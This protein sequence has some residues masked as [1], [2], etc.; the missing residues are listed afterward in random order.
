MTDSDLIKANNIKEEIRE[1]DLFIYSA[2]KVWKGK[3][4]KRTSKYI[5]KS[6][7]FGIFDEVEYHMNTG[8]KNKV[9]DVLREHLQDL[10][11]Q[12]KIL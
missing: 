4:T 3:L 10:K 8:M 12:L 7:A 9:L 11:T 2:E 6:V 5:L 1:L